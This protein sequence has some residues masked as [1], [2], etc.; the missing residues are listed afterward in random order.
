[1]LVTIV[2]VASSDIDK[3]DWNLMKHHYG[4]QC[5][6]KVSNNEAFFIGRHP[7]VNTAYIFNLENGTKTRLEDPPTKAS[8]DSHNEYGIYQPPF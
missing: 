2:P 6:T 4:G 7:K 8:V 5:R 1:M 3:T